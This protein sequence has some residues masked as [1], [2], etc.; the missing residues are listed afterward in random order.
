[1]PHVR[2][3]IRDAVVSRLTGLSATGARVYPTRTY[4]VDVDSLP[5]L[6]VYTLSEESSVDSL[7]TN[8]GLS[9]RLDLIVEAVARVNATLDDTLDA[10]ALE[11][12]TAIAADPTLGGLAKDCTL[13]STRI[14]VRGEAEKETGAAVLTYSVTYRTPAVNAAT[15]I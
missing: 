1:M 11:I 4:P 14:A 13:A 15:T 8:R 5:A 9:R 12:E 10:I 2:K 3:I 7:G 6:C